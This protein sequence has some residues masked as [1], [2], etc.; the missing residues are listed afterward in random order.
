MIVVQ[1]CEKAA[2]QGLRRGTRRRS[3][4]F[5]TLSS[6]LSRLLAVLFGLLVAL[7][8]QLRPGRLAR[9]RFA[10]SNEEKLVSAIQLDDEKKETRATHLTLLFCS[11]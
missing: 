10:G 11:T 4:V 5:S 1:D 6:R 9:D 2:S 8:E 7:G 3:H